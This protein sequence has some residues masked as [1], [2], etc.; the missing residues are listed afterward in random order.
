MIKGVG[1]EWMGL[2]HNLLPSLLERSGEDEVASRCWKEGHEQNLQC[3]GN[4]ASLIFLM[5]APKP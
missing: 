4:P 2:V 5:Q 3:P 1:V